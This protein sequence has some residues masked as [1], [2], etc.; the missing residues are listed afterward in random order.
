MGAAILALVAAYLLG[1]IP[2]SYLVARLR[3]VDV[4]TVGSGNVGATNVMRSAGRAA[5][6]A[7]FA[8]DFLKGTA[9]TL[10][11]RRLAGV[12]VAGAA[13]VAAVLGHMHPVWLRF[14]GGKGVSTGA[15]AFLPLIPIP[16][17]IGLAT[18][19][20]AVALTRYASAGSMAGAT[21]LAVGAFLM[22]APRSLAWAAT[23]TAI[24][25]VWKHRANVRRLAA[26]TERRVG[27][28]PAA[29]P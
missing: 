27:A 2:F 16:T 11:A 18:F 24:L 17:V 9:A 7:A 12:D 26:G 20:I 3:G 13:A 1:S 28:R 25:I 5:G 19:G 21:A 10:L 8:L 23:V 6:L 4:R 14:K 15:G 29:V 22:H